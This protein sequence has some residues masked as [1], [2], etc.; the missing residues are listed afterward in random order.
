MIKNADNC[1]LFTFLGLSRKTIYG[2]F[3]DYRSYLQSN[4]LDSDEQALRQVMKK[5]SYLTIEYFLE[6]PIQN[7]PGDCP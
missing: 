1:R 3:Q 5:V 4:F 7:I 6:S 2:A